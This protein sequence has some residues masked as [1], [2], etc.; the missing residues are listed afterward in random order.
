VEVSF[1][2]PFRGGLAGNL[3]LKEIRRAR[4]GLR[5]SSRGETGECDVPAGRLS[6]TITMRS[7]IPARDALASATGT[8]R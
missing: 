4:E 3:V 1:R 8:A 2:G 7:I 6:Y 5:M